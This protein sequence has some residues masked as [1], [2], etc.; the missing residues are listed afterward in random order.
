MTPPTIPP[1]IP[2]DIK[3][4]AY[5]IVTALRERGYDAGIASFGSEWKDFDIQ[6]IPVNLSIGSKKRN[7]SWLQAY[8][9]D[10]HEV[11]LQIYG[12]R[13]TIDHKCD[14]PSYLDAK[15]YNLADPDA[16]GEM[17]NH[18]LK[19]AKEDFFQYPWI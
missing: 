4:L 12:H 5:I 18:I 1:N 9:H 17:I 16:L 7:R 2:D 6:L 10:K 13:Y 8:W 11:L 19:I 15:L 3:E 14:P